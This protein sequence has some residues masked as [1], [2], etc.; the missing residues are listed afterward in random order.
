M[1][2][3]VKDCYWLSNDFQNQFISREVKPEPEYIKLKLAERTI[4]KIH[5]KDVFI[6]EPKQ[7]YKIAFEEDISDAKTFEFDE[8]LLKNGLLYSFK[9]NHLYLFNTSD[10]QIFLRKGT[11]LGEVFYGWKL[12]DIKNI[13]R[14]CR[15]YF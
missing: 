7:Y 4:H 10:N 5:Y 2:L 15:N 11:I 3:T 6:L 12:T 8:T 14:Y 9:K 1:N 13:I